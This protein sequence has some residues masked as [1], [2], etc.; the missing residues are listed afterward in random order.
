MLTHVAWQR[1]QAFQ[2]SAAIEQELRKRFLAPG[3]GVANASRACSPHEFQMPAFVSAVPSAAT[4]LPWSLL[5][6]LARSLR[7]SLQ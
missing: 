3:A 4:Q 6:R 7:F 5:R 2:G 1:I